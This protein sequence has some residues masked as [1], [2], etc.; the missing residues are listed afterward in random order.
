MPTNDEHLQWLVRNRSRN[1][2]ATFE[3]YG[4]IRTFG[5]RLTYDLSLQTVAQEIAAAAFSLW[6]AVFLSELSGDAQTRMLH[7]ETFLRKLIA[8]N[9]VVYQTDKDSRE[10]TYRYY[11]DNARYRLID[12]GARLSPG[13]LATE[14]LQ[15]K[16]ATEREEWETTEVA[17]EEA[18]ASF[19]RAL[20]AAPIT[21]D[22][23][24]S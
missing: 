19:G 20:A 8:D 22:P 13:L 7:V 9:T 14:R 5:D 24:P 1:Q 2:A 4:L 23:A 16:A 11:V 12:I 18:I 3:L 10:W 15:I 21:G 6:R 17:L